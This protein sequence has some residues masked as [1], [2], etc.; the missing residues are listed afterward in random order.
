MENY[1]ETF[2]RFALKSGA[3][4]FGRFETKSGRLSPYFFNAG[5]LSHGADLEEMGRAYAD[6]IQAHFGD[7]DVLFGPAYKG[8]PISVAAATALYNRHGLDTG[9]CFN[10]KEAKGHGEKGLFVGKKPESGDKVVI[11]DDVITAGTSIRES[12]DMLDEI[13]DIYIMGVM[14]ALDRGERGMNSPL[15]AIQEIEKEFSLP[16]RSIVSVEQILEM[17]EQGHLAGAPENAAGHLKSYL[18]EYGANGEL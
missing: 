13:E 9:Y 10:R 3:L 11:V 1:Q 17:L 16:V 7:V 12:L 2:I 4:R 15:S 5:G 8:I 18:H 14:V 6:A